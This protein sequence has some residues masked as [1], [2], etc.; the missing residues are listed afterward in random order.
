[1]SLTLGLN[2]A[3]SGLLTSQRGL[4]V[5]S[6]NVVNVNTE[7]YHRKVMNPESRVLAGRGAG[8]Q[9]GGVTRMVNE[10]LLKDIRRQNNNMG[11]LDVEKSF[12]D[13]IDTLF[14][15]VGANTSIAHRI[16][17]MQEAFELLAVDVNRPASQ[18]TAMRKTLDITSQLNSMTSEI[19]KLR[20]QADRGIEDTV[21]EINQTLENIHQLNQVIVRNQ[22]ISSGTAD[23]EDKRDT[24]LN[25]LASLIDIQYYRRNDGSVTIYVGSGEMLLDNR[26]HTLSYAATSSPDASMTAASG[27]F[28]HI[29]LAGGSTALEKEVKG[30]KLA[31]LLNMRDTQLPNLQASLDELAASV[32]DVL[33]QIHNRGTSYPNL[34]STYE[35]TRTFAKQ[36]GVEALANDTTARIQVGNTQ[37]TNADFG[38]LDFGYADPSKP[39]LA[40]ISAATAG[41]LS[42]FNAG[43]TFNLHGSGNPANNGTYKVV[44]RNG[45]TLTVQKVNAEQTFS[46]ANGADSVIA[47]FDDQGNQ[48]AYTT[49]SAV[50]SQDFSA[51]DPTDA[52]LAAKPATGPWTVDSFGKH[53]Q[54][55]MRSQN[56][57]GASSASAGLDS[58]GKFVIDTG[59]TGTGLAFRDAV[60]SA[61]GADAA[62][63]TINFDVNGD[64]SPDQEVKGL[65]AFFGLN[66]LIVDADPN[67]VLDSAVVDQRFKTGR[68]RD[69]VLSDTTGQ[70]GNT[71]R[72]PAGASLEDIARQINAQTRTVESGPMASSSFTITTPATLTVSDGSGAVVSVGPLAAGTYSLEELAGRLSQNGV[73]ASVV[74]DGDSY[75]LRLA[76]SGGRDLTVL[77]SGGA[78]AN[79]TSL[80]GNLNMASV[81]RIHA[82]VVPE[83]SGYRLRITHTDRDEIYASSTKD[84]QGGN[85]LSELGLKPGAVLAAGQVTVRE[86]IQ[87]NATKFSRGAVQWD[88]DRQSYYLSEGDATTIQAMAATLSQKSRIATAGS[89]SSGAY[90]LGEY[91]AATISM[92]SSA[93]NAVQDA[94]DYQ[95]KLNASMAF[96]YASYSGVNLDEEVASMMDYQQAY[97]ASAKVIT[98][99]QEMLETLTGMIR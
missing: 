97:T 38:D 82:S 16:G 70:I 1:M 78:M 91:A 77:I 81:Q 95:T 5:I 52:D 40:T 27:Q 45:D 37:L 71:V 75:R 26:P 59:S 36:D 10:G 58:N 96:Q 41:S 17:A 22:A 43:D 14:G 92:A 50:M 33:N 94:H 89:I 79:G 74:K 34:S 46:F 87:G 31:G 84:G 12:L 11:K 29:S 54:A 66:D 13:R 63:A 4:D 55:W 53:L 72:I 98:V 42:G 19:Q 15:E 64:G 88:A 28:G 20:E 18:W 69:L 9:D 49:V 62:D 44:A 85:L 93:S 32:R 60:S 25:K 23:L 35:G 39:W 2:T 67:Y 51:L 48:I 65:S 21:A 47:L 24:E 56:Y 8:V 83:G 68:Q 6:Q 76:D 80:E 73:N 3:L 7:G 86:D 30:G 99:L 57:T 61:A 90:T